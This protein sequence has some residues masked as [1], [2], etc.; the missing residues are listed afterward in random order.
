[1]ETIKGFVLQLAI[2]GILTAVVD[3]VAPDKGAGKLVKLFTALFFMLMVLSPLANFARS[4]V[5]LRVP[6]EEIAISQSEAQ[7]AVERAALAEI[8]S[9]VREQAEQACRT[10]L[11]IEA[12]VAQVELEREE[13]GNILITRIVLCNNTGTQEVEELLQRLFGETVE[14]V[15][16]ED[17]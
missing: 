2:A 1:M 16:D 14:V 8:R 7:D 3:A 17:R 9:A 6:Q 12:E 15:A 13:D 4:G 10:E 11:G 5:N